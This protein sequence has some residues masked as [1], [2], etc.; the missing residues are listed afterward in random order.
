MKRLI[1]TLSALTLSLAGA[2]CKPDGGA[3]TKP[4]FVPVPGALTFNACPTLDEQGNPVADVF[5]DIKKLTI[6]N[7]GKVRA[8]LG[9]TFTGTNADLFSIDGT[10][11]TEIA[12]LDSTEVSIKFSPKAKGAATADLQLDDATEGTTDRKVS[13]VG[14]GINLPSQASLS[15]VT[16]CGLPEDEDSPACT[17]PTSTKTC[18]DGAASYDCTLPFAKT[19]VGATS[20]MKLKIKNLGCPALKITALEI[21]D[22]G[23]GTPPGS[24]TVTT[25]AALPS[26]S[27]PI[28]LTQADGTQETEIVIT[29]TGIDDGVNGNSQAHSAMLIITSN[30]PNDGN[31]LFQPKTIFLTGTATKPSIYVQPTACNFTDT[32][33]LCGNTAHPTGTDTAK[34]KITNEGG[35]T[36]QITAVKFRSSGTST[37]ADG[38]FALANDIVGT[39]L[40][41]GG[42]AGDNVTL[43]VS[44]QDLPLLVQDIIDI[45]ALSGTTSSSIAVSVI[46]GIKPCL[47]TDPAQTLDFGNQTDE[48]GTKTVTIKNGTG[49]GELVLGQVSLDSTTFYSLVDPQVAPGTHVAAG[50]SVTANVQYKRPPSGGQQLATLKIPS[51]DTDFAADGKQ[52]ILQSNAPT[53]LSPTATLTACKPADLLTDPE[54]ASGASGTLVV[55]NNEITPH[56]ITVSGYNST[57]DGPTMKPVKYRFILQGGPSGI[58]PGATLINNGVTGTDSKTKLVLDPGAGGGTTWRVILQVWDDRNQQSPTAAT[59]NIVVY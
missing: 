56:E 55:H 30:D 1:L 16:Q 21:Q 23:S 29:F 2:S 59:I 40:A 18:E 52:V 33:A 8:D 48:L 24:F 22:D 17:T 58:P 31:P 53:D 49:C 36:A 44:Q 6:R 20:T 3:K 32:N 37:R 10:K 11:P 28:L 13:L 19:Q 38:R 54:C 34:F 12:G 41:A 42:T 25:P 46:S 5:G 43:E 57:D 50:A 14:N 27:S 4:D 26:T 47:T 39:T 35:D 15:T 7:D 45:E 9:M 51:N